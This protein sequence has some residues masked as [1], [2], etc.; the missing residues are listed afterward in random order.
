MKVFTRFALNETRIRSNLQDRFFRQ[1]GSTTQV[2]KR[3][4]ECPI[5]GQAFIPQSPLS[6]KRRT[7]VDFVHGRVKAYP[8]KAYSECTC[9]LCIKSRPFRILEI[10][11]PVRYPKMAEV[12]DWIDVQFLQLVESLVCKRPIITSR[13]EMSAIVR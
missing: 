13:P 8:R 7:N 2:L 11:Y 3:G 12:Y 4:H 1:Q 6:G 5:R 9:I 10:A